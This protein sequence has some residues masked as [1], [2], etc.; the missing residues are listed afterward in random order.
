MFSD[1]SFIPQRFRPAV[2]PVNWMKRDAVYLAR[3]NSGINAPSTFLE[4]ACAVTGSPLP[5]FSE[6]PS[7]PW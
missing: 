1:I 6:P 5:F 7:Q 2:P 3:L 4:P